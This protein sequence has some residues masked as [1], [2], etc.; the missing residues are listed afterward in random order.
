[1]QQ[2]IDLHLKYAAEHPQILKDIAYTRAVRR[3]KLPHKAF[4][5]V[6]AGKVIETSRLL[7]STNRSSERKLAMIFSGQGAQWAGMG[8]ELI[9]TDA[10]FREDIAEMDS[11]LQ[12]LRL[13]PS[14]TIMG[15]S[16]AKTDHFRAPLLTRF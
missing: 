14:W 16:K 15:M 8:K 2:Q 1:L 6:Q 9:N 12:S 3:E 5:V 10:C 4:A 7:K 13:P 11:I